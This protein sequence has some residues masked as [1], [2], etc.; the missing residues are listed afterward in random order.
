LKI[1]ATIR[2]LYFPGAGPDQRKT[3]RTCIAFAY[4]D[5]STTATDRVVAIRESQDMTVVVFSD[6]TPPGRGLNLTAAVTM[7]ISPDPLKPGREQQAI[8]RHRI[9]QTEYFATEDL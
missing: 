6:F 3:H 1:S 5:G 8:D 4:F 2:P 9:G 7:Y